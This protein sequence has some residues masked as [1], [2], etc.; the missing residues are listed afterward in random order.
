[1]A[2]LRR[3]ARVATFCEHAR[4]LLD[5]QLSNI[6]TRA[7]C[8]WIFQTI[9]LRMGGM[10]TVGDPPGVRAV[11]EPQCSLGPSQRTAAAPRPTILG[12]AGLSSYINRRKLSQ[13]TALGYSLR[14]GVAAPFRDDSVKAGFC[15]MVAIA[16]CLLRVWLFAFQF[17]FLPFLCS[18][19]QS[20]GDSFRKPAGRAEIRTTF[21]QRVVIGELDF[22]QV[23]VGDPRIY[24]VGDL[25][26]PRPGF[27]DL[28]VGHFGVGDV[29]VASVRD[30]AVFLAP[31]SQIRA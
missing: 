25:D 12:V 9:V 1:M 21:D 31:E 22:P 15:V 16:A 20:A 8:A 3:I 5:P 7:L 17:V 6:A 10:D 19:K 11:T 27:G 26:P 2:R 24:K 28:H 14:G 30:F 18:F 23:G 13:R 4:R 29:V